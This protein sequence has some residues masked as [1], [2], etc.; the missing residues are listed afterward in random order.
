MKLN[1]YN[2]GMV[3][4]MNP[5]V[6]RKYELDFVI[7]EKLENLKSE[8]KILFI[9]DGYDEYGGKEKFSKKIFQL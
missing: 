7:N 9:L 3:E 2:V 1:E 4:K 8:D 6:K 5:L